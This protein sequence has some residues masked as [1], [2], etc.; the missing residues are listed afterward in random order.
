MISAISMDLN[1]LSKSVVLDEES[2]YTIGKPMI[3]SLYTNCNRN[4][5]TM[6]QVDV[7]YL[8]GYEAG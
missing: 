3:Q 8:N 6:K 7:P 1:K 4:I 5:S 2:N